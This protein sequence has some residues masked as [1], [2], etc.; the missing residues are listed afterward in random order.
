[1]L[2]RNR[3]AGRNPHMQSRI[4]HLGADRRAKPAC[5]AAAMAHVAEIA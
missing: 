4:M 5:G 1:M 3:R 2:Q